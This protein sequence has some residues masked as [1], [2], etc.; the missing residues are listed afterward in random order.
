MRKDM[1]RSSDARTSIARR[2]RR[3]D[4]PMKRSTKSKQRCDSVFDLKFAFNKWTLGEEFCVEAWIC[5]RAAGRSEFQHAAFAR[6]YGE[7]IDAA[8]ITSAAR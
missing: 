8:N 5:A 7:E 3:K 2:S 1:A 4:S 6:V